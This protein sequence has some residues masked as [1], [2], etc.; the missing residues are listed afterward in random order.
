M[1]GSKI[2][3]FGNSVGVILPKDVVVRLKNAKGERLFQVEDALDA[4]PLT[5]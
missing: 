2:R 4:Y 5:A 1:V 3:R